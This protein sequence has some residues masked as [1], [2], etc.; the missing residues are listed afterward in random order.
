MWSTVYCVT[1]L[2]IL[3]WDVSL[4]YLIHLKQLSKLNQKKIT[5][6][7]LHSEPK[8]VPRVTL[9]TTSVLEMLLYFFSTP[10]FCT[11][12][13]L[14]FLENIEYQIQT[15]F[16]F[17]KYYSS[18]MHQLQMWNLKFGLKAKKVLHLHMPPCNSNF[19]R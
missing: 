14:V 8:C 19:G 18:Y 17:R 13:K 4:I 1:V 3:Q 15:I 12:I 11:V 10:E 16:K 9:V 2:I 7:I 6:I 5:C